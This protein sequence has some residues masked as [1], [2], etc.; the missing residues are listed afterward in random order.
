MSLRRWYDAEGFVDRRDHTAAGDGRVPWTRRGL[1][2]GDGSIFHP[3]FH[4][5]AAGLPWSDEATW[6]GRS[7]YLFVESVV[8]SL[9]IPFQC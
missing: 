9:I 1:P 8:H 2:Y 5:A 6:V 4:P 7:I 3:L